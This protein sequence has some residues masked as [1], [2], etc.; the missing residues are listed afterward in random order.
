MAFYNVQNIPLVGYAGL[1]E[2]DKS[3][4]AVT[5]YIEDNLSCGQNLLTLNSDL[6]MELL[7]NPQ[8]I[9]PVRKIHEKYGVSCRCAHGAWNRSIGAGEE[10]SLPFDGPRER[11]L[12]R[13]R[14]TIE[15][16]AMFGADTC[17]F[18]T[19]P[20]PEVKDR[21]KHSLQEWCSYVEDALEKVL[22][23]A[24][25]YG[26]VIALENI[27]TEVT[28]GDVLA[29]F[30]RKFDS[31]FLGLCFDAGH[32]NVMSASGTR[33]CGW[34]PRCCSTGRIPWDDDIL[35]KMLPYIVT[36]HLHGNFTDTDTH[37]L[38]SRGNIDWETVK[39]KF[40][41]APRLRSH[42]HEV[43]ISHN[44]TAA[45]IMADFAALMA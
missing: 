2:N 23:H 18:H 30:C 22:P 19:E 21:P 26:V 32:A 41:S 13:I 39:K 25:K 9:E 27:W 33:R 14:Q 8:R 42:Q 4:R 10:M 6:L 38:L 5:A 15:L 40:A 24:E 20:D 16:A 35:D 34:I 28:S 36:T 45:E 43:S 1:P 29:G 31:P 7:D 37:D 44:Y 11:M 12:D 17:A 3:D